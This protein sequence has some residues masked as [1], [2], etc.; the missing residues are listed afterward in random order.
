MLSLRLLKNTCLA[1]IFSFIF[2]PSLFSQN[3]ST[4]GN[5]FWMGFM[6]NT[7]TSSIEL[8]LY[9]SSELNT[10]GT[11]SIPSI[12]WSKSFSVTVGNITK[13]I[14]PTNSAMVVGS[15]KITKQGVH[16]TSGE[17]I[18]LYAM[19]YDGNTFDGSVIMPVK[20]LSNEYYVSSYAGLDY[21]GTV[22][23][24][25]FLVVATEDNTTVQITPT[26]KTAGGKSANV[27]FSINLDKGETYQIQ[28][29]D[30]GD[31]S[32]TKI[33]SSGDN[34]SCHAIAVF[35]GAICTYVGDC[36]AC[37]HLYEQMYPTKLWGKEYV[38]VPLA[39]RSQ[40]TYKIV[41]STNS[42]TVTINNG[43]TIT[44]NLNAGE[45]YAFTE[46][47]TTASI[48]ANQP[49]SVAQ[50]CQGEGCD[51]QTI[52]GDPLMIVLNSNDH[53]LSYANF[54]EIYTYNIYNYYVNVLMKTAY[55]N[56]IKLDGNS[57]S[58]Y[59]SPVPSDPNYSYA[60][61]S[62]TQGDHI[63][64]ADSGFIAYVYGLGN[65]ESFGYAAG[66]SGGYDLSSSGNN[67]FSIVSN[68]DTLKSSLY[69]DTICPG[70]TVG[71]IAPS[72][73]DTATIKWFFGDGDSA[74]GAATSHVY[75]QNGTYNALLIVE[76]NDDCAVYTD[77]LSTSIVVKGAPYTLTSINDSCYQSIGMAIVNFLDTS[78]TPTISWNTNPIQTN[79][80][81]SNL[82]GGIYIVSI[83]YANCFISDTLTVNNIFNLPYTIS[84]IDDT[85]GQALGQASI[86]VSGDTGNCTYS[87]NT[88]PIQTSI[89]ISGL[90][91][92][93]YV[94]TV[95]NGTCL[96]KDSVYINDQTIQLLLGA[97]DETCNH[98]NGLAYVSA[99]GGYGNYTYLWN[100]I[101][102]Q[103]TDT[104]TNLASGIYTITV[105]DGICTAIDSI[106]ISNINTS[107][108]ASFDFIEALNG[109]SQMV[110]DFYN[111]TQNV[112]SSYWIFGDGTFSSEQNPSHIYSDGGD[113]TVQL[114]SYQDGCV[115]TLTKVITIESVYSLTMP[116]VFTPNG[117]G[118][119]DFFLGITQGVNEYE[120]D[121]Y[122]RWG[123]KVYD[124]NDDA[125]PWDGTVHG[126]KVPEGVYYYVITAT[127][128]FGKQHAYNG[129]VQL[130][131]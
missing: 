128:D 24:A 108:A 28:A 29:A 46:N 87:W 111:Y 104:A 130:I 8:T 93:E 82:T 70:E 10:S 68:S 77:T 49:I 91:K 127:D 69:N 62:T 89:A 16:I 115:D 21:F 109:N 33:V 76:I 55:T 117:D 101:N 88:N 39:L 75:N 53:L 6:E 81:I 67:Y 121:I 123:I 60:Q 43:S 71:F 90:T 66:A 30:S 64:K 41:A 97:E 73:V 116:N 112:D 85:C 17:N 61:I 131:R 9:I 110:T 52:I 124:S 122:N 100:T 51:Y 57:I 50:Y 11:V 72:S 120:I 118:I 84:G 98:A 15:D 86:S 2:L 35:G 74:T 42:T 37:D 102:P 107:I 23:P 5:D 27:P 94:V 114:V 126:N 18:S 36:Y 58:S 129:F 103:N 47:Q 40:D 38:T 19:N 106:S 4:K 65:A 99:S 13:V 119:N 22:Y 7:T 63:L 32:G 3:F 56:Q 25:E 44:V 31:L 54:N 48:H 20:T 79:D 80:T 125:S 1:F 83:A 26:T 105:S 12:S 113:Y 14:V 92:G 95:T 34:T 59:F 96:T 45:Q 78:I